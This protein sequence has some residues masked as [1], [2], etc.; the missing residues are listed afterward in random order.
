MLMNL[1][2]AQDHSNRKE[3][4][5]EIVTGVVS[6]PEAEMTQA[7]QAAFR[8]LPDDCILFKLRQTSSLLF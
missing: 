2:K 8:L 4:E 1:K 6:V 3:Q 5:D 7:N